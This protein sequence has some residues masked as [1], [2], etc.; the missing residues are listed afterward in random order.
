MLNENPE[1]KEFDPGKLTDKFL[2]EHVISPTDKMLTE[3]SE[4]VSGKEKFDP[5]KLTD[6][7]LEEH[8]IPPTG[9]EFGKAILA[10][11]EAGTRE[12]WEEI[13]GV[14]LI[15]KGTQESAPC[16]PEPSSDTV[17]AGN[18]AQRIRELFGDEAHQ[19]LV[20]RHEEM[21][22]AHEARKP[23]N[24]FDP[25]KLTDEFAREQGKPRFPSV[26]DR[27]IS[28]MKVTRTKEEWQGLANF[29]EGVF[30]VNSPSESQMLATSADGQTVKCGGELRVVPSDEE[31]KKIVKEV[32][33]MIAAHKAKEEE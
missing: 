30:G 3:N 24:E 8:G 1:E 16:V 5:E 18:F 9:T 6:E 14:F 22:A 15:F 28:A 21:V 23:E 11:R 33:E 4:D 10:M 20:E 31:R 2:E 27:V 26:A 25:E 32:N 19:K 17:K 13:K 12:R 29:Y 7:F